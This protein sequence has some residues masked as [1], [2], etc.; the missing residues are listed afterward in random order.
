MNKLSRK[1]SLGRT[2]IG[3]L[4]LNYKFP[5][6]LL[7]AIIISAF[8]TIWLTQ[9]IRKQVYEKNQIVL[10]IDGLK[11]EWN[12]LVLEE[13]TLTSNNIIEAKAKSLGMDYINTKNEVI[14]VNN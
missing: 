7:I 8:A 11:S 14:I 10:N 9:T 2:I 4:L 5:I 6:L 1:G 3:D 12:S 13:N